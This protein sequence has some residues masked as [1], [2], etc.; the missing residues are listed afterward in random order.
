ME[1]FHF[2]EN[3]RKIRERKNISQEKLA[4]LTNYSQPHIYRLEKQ[5][6]CANIVLIKKLALGLEVP[7]SAIHPLC[8][9][10]SVEVKTEVE[11]EVKSKWRSKLNGLIPFIKDGGL[12]AGIIILIVNAFYDYMEGD[13]RGKNLNPQELYQHKF[14]PTLM[15]FSAL[16][17]IWCFYV[18]RKRGK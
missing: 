4:E 1:R 5:P 3:L 12:G 6:E 18:F 13:A 10:S 9:D 11:Q 7:P 17:I 16:V 8:A 14:Y 2:G 15:V